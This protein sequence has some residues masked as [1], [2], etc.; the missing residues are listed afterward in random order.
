MSIVEAGSVAVTYVTAW[1]AVMETARLKATNILLVIG[2][3]GGVGS[4]AVQIARWQGAKVMGTVRR[5]DDRPLAETIGAQV[6]INLENQDLRQSVLEVTD[7]Q[8]A[9]VILDTVRGAMVET[10]L[11]ALSHKG[12]LLE[13]SAPLGNSRI[14][15]DLRDFY[16]REAKLLG[17]DSRAVDVTGC[18]AIL[19][20]LKP[21]FEAK[22]LRL[23]S[24]TVTSYALTEAIEAYE[25]SANKTVRGRAVLIS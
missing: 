23:M 12:R 5:E 6:V 13:I 3:T 8:G 9:S 20:A 25:Q 11:Q 4:A 22:A 2:S 17:V 19:S 14:S 7:G 21:G 10:C 1:L 15:F 16:H 24:P 18:A